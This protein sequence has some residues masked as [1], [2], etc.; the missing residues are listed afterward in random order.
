MTFSETTF[1]FQGEDLKLY[2]LDEQQ[3][4]SVAD[5]PHLPPPSQLEIKPAKINIHGG[6]EDQTEVKLED[7]EGLGRSE[8]ESMNTPSGEWG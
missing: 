6:V 7:T 1:N 2:T 4:R 8:E 5:C 3:G